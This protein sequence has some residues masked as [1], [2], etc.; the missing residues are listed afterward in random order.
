MAG[1]NKAIVIGNLGGDPDVR[2]TQD[3]RPVVSFQVA[4]SETWRDKATGEKRENTDWHRV[5][6]FNEALCK[7]AEQYLKKGSRV[8]LEGAMKTRKWTDNANVERY[9]TEVVL[10]AFGAQLVLCDRG[11]G[12][13]PPADSPESYGKTS[14]SG[15]TFAGAPASSTRRNEIDD[16]IPF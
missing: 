14:A 9:T 11:P 7:I 10:G 2:R 13:V 5:V 6:I 1:V 16:E 12:G 4:T 3:G 15:D 8:Y